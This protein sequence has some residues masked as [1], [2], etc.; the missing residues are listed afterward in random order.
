[1]IYD[2]SVVCAK[3]YKKDGTNCVQCAVNEYKDQVSDATTCT[4]CTGTGISTNGAQGATSASAC[5]KV[6]LISLLKF[7]WVIS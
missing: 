3:G 7:Y 6:S 4:P 2:V 1:M 5:G